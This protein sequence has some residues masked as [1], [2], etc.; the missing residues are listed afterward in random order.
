VDTISYLGRKIPALLV[1]LISAVLVLP[2]CGTTPQYPPPPSLADHERPDYLIGP[3][4]NINI[5]VWRQPELTLS[6]P[7]RP[8]GRISTP[9]VEDMLASG[10]TPT[11]LARE[12]E[13]VLATY[14]RDPVVTVITTGF[15]GPYSQQVRVVGQAVNPQSIAY[16]ENMTALDVMIAVGGLADFAAG[17]RARI[18]RTVDGESREFGVRLNDLVKRGRIEANVAM[19]PGD[20]LIIPETW[21]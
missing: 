8:D 12:M 15:V 9:L 6:V 11:Q 5:F 13:E 18:I 7:V 4:D 21:F 3:G 19:M 16:R 14:V 2:A 20:I 1:L 17:N 10:K